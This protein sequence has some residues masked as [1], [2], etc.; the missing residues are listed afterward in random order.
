[1][2]EIEAL[3]AE[4]AALK[5]QLNE[6]HSQAI[7]ANVIA[8]VSARVLATLSDEIHKQMESMLDQIAD[9]FMKKGLHAEANDLF[10][11]SAKSLRKRSTY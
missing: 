8:G 9:S 6:A 4:V 7:T 2:S 10:E 3:K 1:M 11:F 5:E